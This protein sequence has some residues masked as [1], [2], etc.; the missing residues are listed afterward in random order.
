MPLPAHTPCITQV[1]SAA[2]MPTTAPEP[3][4]SFQNLVPGSS[5]TF[6]GPSTY[7]SSISGTFHTTTHH[8]KTSMTAGH[9]PGYYEMEGQSMQNRNASWLPEPFFML[10]PC[11]TNIQTEGT[12]RNG[13]VTSTRQCSPFHRPS[14]GRV[15]A[16]PPAVGVTT[17]GLFDYPF[18]A[19]CW[20]TVGCKNAEPG[21]GFSRLPFALPVAAQNVFVFLFFIIVAV[22]LLAG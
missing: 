22:Y 8:A 21:T 13:L 2:A 17:L 14:C 1:P 5:S 12:D 3:V 6:H 7:D 19:A 16:P 10:G 20:L 11:G 4:A 18:L 15:S 9:V